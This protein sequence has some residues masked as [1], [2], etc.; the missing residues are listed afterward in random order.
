VSGETSREVASAILRVMGEEPASRMRAYWNE[1]ARLNAPWYVDTSLDYHHPDMDLFFASGESIVAE[2]LD[3][4]PAVPAHHRLAVEIGSGLGRLCKPLAERFEEVIGLDISPEMVER[5]RELV[6]HPHI[7]FR[8]S[9]GSDLD[10]VADASADLV[11]SF[12]VF[13]HISDRRIIATYVHEIGRILAPGGVAAFQWNS[14][15]HPRLWHLRGRFVRAQ[16]R[17]AGSSRHG[18]NEAGFLGS[19]VPVPTM[20]AWLRDAGLELIETRGDGSLWTWAWATK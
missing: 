13:Q 17:F 12:T 15:R 18:T 2:A 20:R 3:G 6:E 5:A 11:L 16:E 19:R 4:A 1:R 14:G 7:Q 8:V 9:S 10:N